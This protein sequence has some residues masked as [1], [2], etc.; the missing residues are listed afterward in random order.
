M[1]LTADGSS[2]PLEDGRDE[3]FRFSLTTA[4][5]GGGLEAAAATWGVAVSLLEAGSGD[6]D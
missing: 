3:V 1:E 6:D 2:L 5:A 4:A